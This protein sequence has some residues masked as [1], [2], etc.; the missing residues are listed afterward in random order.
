MAKKRKIL[1]TV[2]IFLFFLFGCSHKYVDVKGRSLDEKIVDSWEEL[3]C[4]VVEQNEQGF[5]LN[6]KIKY[7]A[8]VKDSV[9]RKE[10]VKREKESKADILIALGMVV[11]YSGGLGSYYYIKSRD[12]LTDEVFETGC[13]ISSVSC[14][15]G[16][17][18][19]AGGGKRRSV[20]VKSRS[21][22]I[23]GDTICV[24][25]LMLSKGKIEILM[26]NSNFEK[27][28]YTDENGN[29]ELEFEEIIP[30]PTESDSTIDLIIRCYELVDTVKVRRL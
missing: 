25:S 2:I 21:G 16:L 12:Y 23:K 8:I 13:F 1:K 18:M 10:F 17:A 22:L 20:V 9:K 6:C 30:E 19:I 11:I 15:A 26:E 29:I 3:D 24:D 28:Y 27:T 7:M 4:G 5:S 14:L